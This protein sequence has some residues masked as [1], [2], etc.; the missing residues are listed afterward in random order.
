MSS[1]FIYLTL[2][3]STLR[4]LSNDLMAKPTTNT[5]TRYSPSAPRHTWS[6][7]NTMFF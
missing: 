1:Y 3:V 2:P 7:I 5:A 6:D 4:M